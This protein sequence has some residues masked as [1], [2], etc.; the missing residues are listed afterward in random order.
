MKMRILVTGATGFLAQHL[1]PALQKRGHTIRALVL[2]S[3]DATWLLHRG[4]DI[5]RG[6]VRQANT[7]TQP[8]RDVDAVFHLAAAIGSQPV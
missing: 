5:Y 7:L 2:P 3:G 6:D 4:V 8:L 1:I